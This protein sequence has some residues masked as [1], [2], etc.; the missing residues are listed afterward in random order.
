MNS[1]WRI[2]DVTAPPA[3]VG[4]ER[5]VIVITT[6]ND[7]GEE[8]VDRVVAADIALTLLGTVVGFSSGCFIFS[9]SATR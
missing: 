9:P 3:T 2:L 1:G 8:P 6:W 5:G 4:V 7:L